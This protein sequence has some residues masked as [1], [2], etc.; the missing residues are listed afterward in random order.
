MRPACPDLRAFT[1]GSGRSVCMRVNSSFSRRRGTRNWRQKPASHTRSSAASRPS[2]LSA[3][4]STRGAYLWGDG[5][6]G[7]HMHAEREGLDER[8]VPKHRQPVADHLG[9]AISMQ[10]ACNQ[11][12]IVP[13]HRQP[14]ADHLGELLALLRGEKVHLMRGAIS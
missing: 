1:L 13:K 9:D 3:E 7:E 8:R 2:P 5:R 14:V 12:A 11:H 6:H 4:V 10:S